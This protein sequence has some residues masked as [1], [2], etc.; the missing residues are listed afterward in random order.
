MG[1][2]LEQSGKNSVPF[3]ALTDLPNCFLLPGAREGDARLP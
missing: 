2:M 1:E 3:L